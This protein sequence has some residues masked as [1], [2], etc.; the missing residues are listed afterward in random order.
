MK[1]PDSAG[2]CAVV[3]DDQ[4]SSIVTS[5]P[6]WVAAAAPGSC[7]EPVYASSAGPWP[8]QPQ[9]TSASDLNMKKVQIMG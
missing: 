8:H 6:A 5:R 3:V 4:V 1:V 2:S 7:V 9:T